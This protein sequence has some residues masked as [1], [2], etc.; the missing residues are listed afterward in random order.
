MPPFTITDYENA[1][2]QASQLEA[3]IEKLKKELGEPDK[4]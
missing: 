2:E 4:K 3:K 1:G